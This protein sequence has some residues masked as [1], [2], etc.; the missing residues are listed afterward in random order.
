[1]AVQRSSPR[2]LRLR[3]LFTAVL[4]GTKTIDNKNANLFLEAIRD[5]DDNKALYAQKIQASDHGR[6]AFR[7]AL[8]SSTD[9]CFLQESITPTLRYLAAPELKTLCGGTVLQQ[10]IAS[11]I[12]AEL[13]WDAYITA[14]KAGQLA[15]DGEEA[16]S[17]LLLELLSLPKE[18]ANI[19]VHLAQDST[20]K[21][22]LLE[23]CKQSVRLRGHRIAHIVENLVA[24]H[25]HHRSNQLPGGSG[26]GGRHNNDFAEINRIAILP[27]T[28]ELATKDP[29]LPRAQETS[30]L[31]KRPDGVAFYLDGHFRL[32]RED[33]LRDLREEIQIA[34]STQS[35]GGG[36]VRKS[37]S[38]EHLSMVGVNCDGRNPWSLQLQCMNDLP[39]MPKKSEADRKSFLKDN[40]KYLKHESLACIIA[41]NEVVTLGTLVRD[42]NLLAANPPVICLQIPVINGDRA[43]RDIKEAK[44]V[45]LVQLNTTMFSYAPILEQL[46]E[47]K[48]LPFEDEILRWDGSHRPK[49]PVYLLSPVVTDLVE[50]L[51]CNFSRDLQP[52]LELPGPTKL[53]RSQAECFVTGITTRLS[54][55]QGP[56]GE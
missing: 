16:F 6:A 53:D 47:M 25:D 45:K 9:L 8:S 30:E 18:K 43:L 54:T 7:I 3:T 19:F 12:E 52:A 13:V 10:L 26:P 24:G 17:W 4:K 39:Q 15:D 34:L 35:K 49:P 51:R 42:E 23:S 44:A 31:V 14:F 11:F 55:I 28:D 29:Y 22:T 20:I 41:D 56:P 32:L 21:R 27:T 36:R 48:E 38:V 37:F 46:K 5:Q 33:M 40:P 2:S 1:M 50:D